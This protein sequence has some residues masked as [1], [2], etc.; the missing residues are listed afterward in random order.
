MTATVVCVKSSMNTI[1]ICL[2]LTKLSW[3]ALT[4]S[5]MLN[6]RPS[7]RPSLGVMI[8][9]HCRLPVTSGQQNTSSYSEIRSIHRTTAN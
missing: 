5:A 4:S 3:L 6:T 1:A 9:C 7:L 8:T 2:L